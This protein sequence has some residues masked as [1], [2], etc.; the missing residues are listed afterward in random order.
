MAAVQRKQTFGRKVESGGLVMTATPG[1]PWQPA[2]QDSAPHARLLD[3]PAIPPL[4]QVSA[5]SIPTTPSPA[6]GFSSGKRMH[7]MALRVSAFGARLVSRLYASLNLNQPT[8]SRSLPELSRQS[9]SRN[10]SGRRSGLLTSLRRG[11]AMPGLLALGMTLL[12]TKAS[13]IPESVQFAGTVSTLGSGFSNPY[14]VAVDKAGDVFV[15]DPSNNAVKEIVA[16][17]GSIPA[18]PTILTLGSGFKSPYGVALDGAGDVFV[19]DSGNSLVK[20][21]VAVNGSIPTTN[22]TIRTLGSGFKG[23]QGVA[24]DGAGDVFVSDPG[25][26]TLQEIVAAGGSIPASPTIRTLTSGF[27]VFGIAVD[28]AG[29]VYFTDP[30]HTA[31]KEI[32]AA[33]GS[34]PA[35]PTILTLYSGFSFPEGVAVDGSGDVFVADAGNS[36]VNEV[37]AVNGSIPSSNPTILTLG[38]GFNSPIGVT[39]DGFGDVFVADTYNSAVKEIQLTAPNF[40]AVAIGATPRPTLTFNFNFITGATLGSPVVVTQGAQNLDFSNAGSGTCTSGTAFTAGQTCTVVVQFSPTRPGQ[41]MGAVDLVNSTGFVLA[42]AR[43]NGIGTGPSVDFPTNP[44]ATVLGSGFSYPGGLAVD[45]SG[46]IYFGDTGTSTIKQIASGK[47]S[48]AAGTVTVL[49]TMPSNSS[50]IGVAV[51]GAGNL[52]YSDT[53]NNLVYELLAGTGGAAPG[54]VTASSTSISVGGFNAPTGLA[55]DGMGNVYVADDKNNAVKEILAGTGGAAPGK[56]SSGSTVIQIGS[57]F[58]TPYDVAVDVSGNVYVADSGH[59]EIKEILAGT[60]GAAAGTVNASSTVNILYN[61]FGFEQGVAVDA[62]GN[63]YV[64]DNGGNAVKEILAGTGGAAVGTINTSSTMIKL[65]TTVNGGP[66]SVAVDGVGNVYFTDSANNAIKKISLQTPPSLTFPSTNENVT[67]AAQTVLV[68]NIGNAALIFPI[69]TSGGNPSVSTNF[70]LGSSTTCPTLTSSSGSA[71]MI[72]ASSTCSLLIDFTPTASGSLSGSVNLFDTNLNA[73]PSVEQTIPVSGTGVQVA[74]A[75]LVYPTTPTGTSATPQTAS[76][77]IPS[78]KTVASVLVVTQGIQNLDFTENPSSTCAGS[79]SGSC[80]VVVDFKPQAPGMRLGAAILTLSDG[81]TLTKYVSGIGEGPVLQFQPGAMSTVAGSGQPCYGS[82]GVGC[83]DGTN[84]LAA[85]FTHG[86]TVIYDAAG[87]AFV[88]DLGARVVRKITPQGVVSTVAGME[89]QACATTAGPGCGDGGP[90]TSAT[91]QGPSDMAIDGAGNLYLSD[92]GDNRVRVVNLV[93]GTINAYAGNGNTCSN[94]YAA[95]SCG[96]GGPAMSATMGSIDGIAVD[97]QGNVYIGDTNDYKIREVMQQTGIITTIGGNGTSCTNLTGT[98]GDGGLATAAQ[99]NY[100]NKLRLDSKGNIYFADATANRARE[101]N[102]TTGIISTVAGNGSVCTSPTSACGD[103]G[104]ATNAQIGTV[105]GIALDGADNLYVVDNID[106]KIRFVNHTTGIISTVV[107]NG[108]TCASP[109]LPCGD[110]GNG[111]E[112][113]LNGPVCVAFNPQGNIDVCDNSDFK[114][115]QLSFDASNLSFA[116]TNVGAT[117]TDSPQSVTIVNAGN[118]PL[119]FP[120]PTTGTNPS[121]AAGFAID[122]NSHVT[123]C[124]VVTTSGTASNIVIGGSCAI[125]VDFT[126]TL[127]GTNDGSLVLTDNNFGQANQTQTISLSGTGIVTVSQLV[128]TGNPAATVTAGGNAGSA[129][130]VSEEN[131]SSNVVTAATDTITLTVTGP[132]GYSKTYT[133]N[134]VNGVATFNLSSVPLT[135]AG[136]YTYSATIS[137]NTSITAGAASETVNSGTA[138][139]TTASQGATQ[140][141]VIGA[142][143]STALQVQV[144]DAYSNPVGGV[145]VSFTPPATGASAVLSAASCTTSTTAPVGVC[146]VTATANGTASATA[147]TVVAKAAGTSAAAGF[148]LTNLKAT[149]TVTLSAAPS[150]LVYGQ[151][152]SLTA[153]FAPASVAGTTPTAGM[154]FYD[155]GSQLS[156]AA[157]SSGSAKLTNLYPAAGTHTYTTSYPGDTNFNAST[158]ATAT[159]N[160]TVTKAS[161]T[162]SGPAKQPVQLTQGTAGTIAI[163]LA[164]Q[165]SGTGIS[166]PSGTVS[167][168]I[169][170]GVT[171]TA[172]ISNGVATVAVPNTLAPGTYTA[173]ITYGGDGNYNTATTIQVSVVVSQIAQTITFTPPAS[174]VTYGAGPISLS[175]TATSNLPVTFSVVSGPGTISGSQLSITGAG[176]IVIAANQAGNTDYSAAS[177][178]TQTVVVNKATPTLAWAKPA[179]IAYGTALSATQLDA[180][181]TGVGG[182]T[183]AGTFTYS[184]T[185]GTVLS[186][187]GAGVIQSLGVVFTPTDTTDYTTAQDAVGITVN[188]AAPV[189]KWTT[190]TAISYGVPLSATQLNATVLGVNGQAL[191]GTTVY[192]PALGTYLTP[193]THTLQVNFT[194]TDN[195]DYSVLNGSVMLTVNKAAATLTTQQQSISV[196]DGQSGSIPVA[197]AGQYSGAGIVAPSA[198]VTYN[199]VNASSVTVATGTISL[200]SGAGSVP[201]PSTLAPGTYTVDLSYGGDGNYA[202]STTPVAVQLV[203]NQIQPT[204]SWAQPAAITYGTNLAGVL[205]AVAM[206]GTTVVPGTMT[207]TATMAGGGAT[208]VNGTTVL[209]AGMYTLTATFTPTSTTTYKTATASVSLV[210][211]KAAAG[212]SLTTSANTVLVQNPVTFTATVASVAGMP[213]GTV[214]FF[215][216]STTSTPIGAAALANGMAVL[217]TSALTTGTHTITAVYSGDANHVAATS[218][219]LVQTVQDFNLTISTSAGGATTATAVPGGTASYVFTLSPT[220]A[221]TFPANVALSV[222]GLPTGATYTLSPTSIQAGSGPTNVTLKVLVPNTTMAALHHDSRPQPGKPTGQPWGRGLAPIA[223]GVLLLPFT[224]RMRKMGKRMGRA[225]TLALLLMVGLG[226]VAGLSGCGTTTGYFGQAEHTYTVSITGTSGA[227]VHST[228]VTLNVQ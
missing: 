223:L 114:I 175:A 132:G 103:G 182:T 204:I 68:Q 62:A 211:N 51:D 145:V 119:I 159:P 118:A 70:G 108:N 50:P 26:L 168:S 3:S 52:Y 124:P 153:T 56:I 95:N 174:S 141:A 23:P 25:N 214:S 127:A 40:G 49:A 2:R 113:E 186:A 48:V 18:N 130:T 116:S 161:V 14:A 194:P 129:I 72:G 148:A 158:K 156:S 39:V 53:N 21:I 173:T 121:I 78:G 11:W 210:V 200:S 102:V 35:S 24:V 137:G 106:N 33:G 96:D 203:V 42:T 169:G 125:G 8:D 226:T 192:T 80:N 201:I 160:V 167:F 59:N 79:S 123:T 138:S 179:A 16:V 31:V 120:V 38:G 90:A 87:N 180:T 151:P 221:S 202:A 217:T 131:A 122:S 177:Q 218:P 176:T 85:S 143:F 150:T 101:I 17:H 126:P 216:G 74:P 5:T 184:P 197:V 142:A 190:P 105:W 172:T 154:L 66:V 188:P 164:G 155:N 111:A 84:P 15:A 46:N 206:D 89:N 207:Y 162:L 109:S 115:R 27:E 183:L 54:T 65:A 107:G 212:I 73:S 86:N 47:G 181:A 4:T 69:P 166:T 99:I 225:V 81:S 10:A 227:L 57:N 12:G 195:T 77:T 157:V 98:C 91:M 135:A 128:F 191:A 37:V 220:G 196:A 7:T 117:S 222:S 215:D 29:D 44:I 228:T 28:G 36:S 199:I 165:Y 149:P 67:S 20:E 146:S 139:T 133:A 19:A 83:G 209:M 205:N 32:V 60:G 63:V 43:V 94:P 140:S 58:Q 144:T 193:G 55:V 88:A 147:Y 163:N 22:P 1:C 178:V 171:G 208:A 92:K 110:G 41:R 185:V 76:F 170:S 152:E 136:G 100:P 134:A 93:T 187:K 71:G 30:N 61:G 64:S 189:L 9:A 97:P 6:I 213:T 75:S 104:L 34:I 219:A 82:T 13:A 45:G 224:R 198:T 112:A